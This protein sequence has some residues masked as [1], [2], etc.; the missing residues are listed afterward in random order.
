MNSFYSEEEL[1]RVGFQSYGK[2]VL[3]SR[4]VSIYG[5]SEISLGN[6]IRIDDFCI[7]SGKIRLGHNIHLAAY[8][9]LWGGECGITICDFANVSSR[10]CV[11]ALSDD[12]SG[13]SMTNPTVPEKYKDIQNEPVYIGRH[14]II[15]SGSTI[16]PGVRLEEGAALGAMSMMKHSA[17]AWT[18]YAGI[19]ACE[20]KP[21]ERKLLE[22]ERE[23]KNECD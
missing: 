14:V 20:I 4:K 21:R 17:K 3:V 10:V 22:L 15:G 1:S 2:N 19:P 6:N 16:L 5:A 9:A 23:Y 8:T 7:L 13:C 11:Y 12:Y 18:I